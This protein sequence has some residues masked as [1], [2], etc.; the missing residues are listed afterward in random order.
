MRSAIRAGWLKFGG[1]WHDPVPDADPARPLA[2]GTEEH[3]G[4]R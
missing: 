2:H 1:S 3:L 4:R